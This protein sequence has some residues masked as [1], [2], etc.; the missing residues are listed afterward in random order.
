MP[1]DRVAETTVIVTAT[2]AAVLGIPEDPVTLT[3]VPRFAASAPLRLPYVPCR[4]SRTRV[5]FVATYV[6]AAA[7]AAQ[8]P[9]ARTASPPAST[10]SRAARTDSV[11]RTR[12][13]SE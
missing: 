13:L 3:T 12:L 1:P 6:P 9:P 11:R 8:A 7:P 10:T 2:E 4:V 5:G